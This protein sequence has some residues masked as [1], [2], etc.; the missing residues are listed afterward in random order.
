MP[1]TRCSRISTAPGIC[2]GAAAVVRPSLPEARDT[3]AWSFARPVARRTPTSALRRDEASPRRK[4]R[5]G[6]ASAPELRERATSHAVR[7]RGCAP[8]RTHVRPP[9][10]THCRSVPWS[11]PLPSGPPRIFC[12][13]RPR[14]SPYVWHGCGRA[15]FVNRLTGRASP[16]SVRPA[17]S[18]LRDLA[19]PRHRGGEAPD[20]G[21]EVAEGRTGPSI[22]RAD[23]NDQKGS[24]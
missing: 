24:R 13:T 7:L 19:G 20:T 23:M 22:D 12:A 10:R 18:V 6:A 17:E 5:G 9:V 1:T 11:A 21:H 2:A 3:T 16:L 4:R 14:A 8:V 15:G